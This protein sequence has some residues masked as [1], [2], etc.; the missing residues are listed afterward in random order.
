MARGGRIIS[1]GFLIGFLSARGGGGSGGGGGGGNSI[2]PPLHTHFDIFTWRLASGPDARLADWPAGRRKGWGVV[3]DR[4]CPIPNCADDDADSDERERSVSGRKGC[5]APNERRPRPAS[6]LSHPKWREC[7]RLKTGGG[8][9]L[10]CGLES[11]EL[12]LVVGFSELHLA[13]ADPAN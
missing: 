11:P 2:L 1:K 10:C 9:K 13:A 7:R 6:R 12:V 5:A 4:L 3:V 8:R